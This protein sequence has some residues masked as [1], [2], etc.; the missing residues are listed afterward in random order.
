MASAFGVW[1]YV[2]KDFETPNERLERNPVA[3]KP[4]FEY[5]E[6][7]AYDWKRR[8]RDNHLIILVT[9][10]DVRSYSAN[11]RGSDKT[12]VY[13]L[14]LKV[15]TLD[16]LKMLNVWGT[17]RSIVWTYV[18]GGRHCYKIVDDNDDQPPLPPSSDKCAKLLSFMTDIQKSAEFL[19]NGAVGIRNM[20]DIKVVRVVEIRHLTERCL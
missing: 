8:M 3:T 1:L 15:F 2:T 18:G 16:E 10:P 4:I 14:P 13:V 12:S 9:T 5:R 6:F 17:G 19:G 11:L 7:D 20:C